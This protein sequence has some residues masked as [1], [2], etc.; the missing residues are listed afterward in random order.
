[1]KMAYDAIQQGAIG[2]DMGRNIWQ[3]DYPVAMI[4]AIRAVVHHNATPR[5]AVDVFSAAK[6]GDEAEEI[7]TRTG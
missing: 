1:M 2:V 5:E 7:P 4:K 3:S 6:N